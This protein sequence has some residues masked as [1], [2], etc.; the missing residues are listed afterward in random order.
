MQV[1]G[2][3]RRLDS[4][5]ANIAAVLKRIDLVLSSDA[6]IAAIRSALDAGDFPTLAEQ[7]SSYQ[8]MQRAPGGGGATPRAPVA[9]ADAVVAQATEKLLAVVREEV[10]AAMAAGDAAAAVRFLK[11]Y[12]PLDMPEEGLAAAVSFV[13]KCATPC[14]EATR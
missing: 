13:K 3:V 7:I 1:S 4:A 11:L 8:Q 10:K 2:R 6:C 12:K 9:A 5:Q 14:S